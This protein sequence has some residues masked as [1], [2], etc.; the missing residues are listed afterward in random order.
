MNDKATTETK[1]T[2]PERSHTKEQA[3]KAQASTG[4]ATLPAH[5]EAR[6]SGPGRRRIHRLKTPEERRELYERACKWVKAAMGDVEIIK[7]PI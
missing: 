1:A 3:A 7:W 6:P 4:E 5:Q 2:I